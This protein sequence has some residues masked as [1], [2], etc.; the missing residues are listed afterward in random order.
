[1]LECC[2]ASAGLA[3]GLSF[4]SWAAS[5]ADCKRNRSTRED[6]KRLRVAVESEKS[7]HL[8]AYIQ[9]IR[10][11]MEGPKGGYDANDK[12]RTGKLPVSRRWEEYVKHRNQKKLPVIGSEALFKKLWKKHTE[13]HEFSAKGHPQCDMC[14]LHLSPQAPSS[15]RFDC[16][17]LVV[18]A[19][20]RISV[21]IFADVER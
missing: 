14:V 10:D 6:R 3:K 9:S 2:A 20:S 19:L 8:N 17:A 15:P 21:V 5:R 16:T 7:A 4:A 11:T 18:L 1:M 12:W 13:I